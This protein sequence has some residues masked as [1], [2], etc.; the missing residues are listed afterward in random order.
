MCLQSSLAVSFL[1]KQ[2]RPQVGS[3]GYKVDRSLALVLDHL[4]IQKCLIRMQIKIVWLLFVILIF[5]IIS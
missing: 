5:V 4:H 2:P 1:L 3:S